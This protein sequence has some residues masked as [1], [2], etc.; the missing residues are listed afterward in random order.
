MVDRREGRIKG[1]WDGWVD[2]PTDDVGLELGGQ[3]RALVTHG[4]GSAA[5][6]HSC[7]G[8]EIYRSTTAAAK[9]IRRNEKG[10]A[11]VEDE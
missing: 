1:W 7:G 6:T 4:R 10:A 9:Q 5:S 11:P 8:G 2:V 3:S